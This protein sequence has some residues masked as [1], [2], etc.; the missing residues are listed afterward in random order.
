MPNFTI[1]PPLTISEDPP[2]V[3]GSLGEA[4]AF[5]RQALSQ[6]IN[7]VTPELLPRLERAATPQQAEEAFIMFKGWLEDNGLMEDEGEGT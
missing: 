1:E 3:I 7:G 2:I 5:V 6:N 4:A